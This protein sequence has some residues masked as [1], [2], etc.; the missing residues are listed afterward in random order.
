MKTFTDVE[1]LNKNLNLTSVLHQKN[2]VKTYAKKNL[3]LLF[4]VQ[5]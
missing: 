1:V 5:K 2:P 3:F 4:A